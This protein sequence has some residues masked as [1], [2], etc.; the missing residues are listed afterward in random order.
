MRLLLILILLSTTTA[1]APQPTIT[2]RWVDASHARIT[3]S[4]PGCI[5][6]QRVWIGCADQA[7]SFTL[8][9][10]QGPHDVALE[11]FAG[12]V[13]CLETDSGAVVCDELRSLVGLPWVG[14]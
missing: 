11:P 4:A 7:G 3:I 9:P 12:A 14:R 6:N 8:P 5:S 1:P 10:K 2:A 13:Y